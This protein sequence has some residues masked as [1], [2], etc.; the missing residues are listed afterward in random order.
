MDEGTSEEH[1]SSGGI[2]V[3]VEVGDG[4][5]R[6]LTI[7]VPP[8]SVAKARSRERDRLARSIR[9]KGF[10]KGK[11][12]PGVVEQRF[13]REIDAMVR[14]R[15]IESAYREAV[16]LRELKPAGA[17][18][19]TNVQYAPGDRLTFQAE[20]EIMPSVEIA[21]DGGFR[22]E[23]TVAPVTDEEVAGILER[24]RA[25]FAD[26]TPVERRPGEGD[27]VA[28]RV[29]PL[30]EGEETPSAEA[31]PYRF[32]LGSGQALPGVEQAIASLL[33]GES[34]SFNVEFPDED[35]GEATQRRLHVAL[36]EVE[37]QSLAELTDELASRATGG[38]RPT[39]AELETAVREDLARHHE[40]EAEERVRG[41]LLEALVDA[42]P[43]SVPATL[44]D[45][46]VDGMLG[47]PEGA[48][49]E[50]LKEARES[51]RPHAEKRIREEFVLDRIIERESLE[52]GDEELDAHIA[53]MAGRRGIAPAALRRQLEKESRLGTLR[54]NLAVD[55]AF[56][57]LKSR[58]GL[59]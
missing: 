12:P 51:L 59:A 26:W 35:G 44:V 24:I 34:G 14:E 17:A 30:A 7:T 39:V 19:I 43:F 40:K 31:R 36:D 49:S 37:E 27:R 15:L 47:D 10:R 9:L 52:P 58:S 16:D 54:R 2:D 18:S 50:E 45:R 11:V 28:V 20:L 33:P 1:G 46:T 13:G 5:S 48:G 21:R 32:V 3:A 22:I 25:D 57:Y 56:E 55:K 42:N 53:E 38:D 6:K 23:R 41:A 29:A 8:E 4:W